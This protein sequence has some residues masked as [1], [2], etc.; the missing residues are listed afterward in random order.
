MGVFVKPLLRIGSNL[1]LEPTSQLGHASQGCI[2]L[3]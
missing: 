3:K 1:E 2:Q